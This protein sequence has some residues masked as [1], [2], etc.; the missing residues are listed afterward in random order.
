MDELSELH[1]ACGAVDAL[2]REAGDPAWLSPSE[3]ARLEALAPEKRRP[4]VAA[5]WQARTL[6]AQVLGGVATD[7]V[8]EAPSVAPP[9]V[10][11]RDDLFLSVSH[12]GDRT[13]CALA[14]RRI[15]I[16]LEQP[17][18][19]HDASRLADLCCTPT[20]RAL[21]LSPQAALFRELWTV[22]QAWLK[23]RGEWIAPGRLQLLEATPR[24]DGA[25]RTWRGEGWHLAATAHQARWWGEEPRATRAWTV[26]DAARTALP[27]R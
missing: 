6:L 12:S 7:W 10:R 25:V 11:G 16:D 8:L 2:L 3:R 1:L 15:G 21:F 5:R 4:F 22:K 13:A 14:G 18:P 27:T 19:Q 9:R 24:P 23:Q 17:T 26:R 20:E